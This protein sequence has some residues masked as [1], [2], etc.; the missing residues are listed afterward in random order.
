ILARVARFRSPRP[1]AMTP[2]VPHIHEATP[3]DAPGCAAILNAWIDATPWLPR[4]HPA[5]DVLRHYRDVVL[6][7]RRVWVA[8][9]PV[10]GFLALDTEDRTVTALYLAAD[11]RCAG[12]G[13]RLL[14]LAKT[15]SGRLGLWTFQANH[16]ARRFYERH[17]FTVTDRSDGDNEEGLP[18]LRYDWAAA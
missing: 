15:A 14:T 4:I 3:A 12:L 11:A 9:T 13:A 10:A 1:A 17:R 16:G 8:G 7:R 5:D 6:P 2:S 18:D